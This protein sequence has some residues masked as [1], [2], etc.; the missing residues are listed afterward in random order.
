[1]ENQAVVN[2]TQE[3]LQNTIGGYDVH[4]GRE[5]IGVIY[6]LTYTPTS[7]L[8]PPGYWLGEAKT[9]YNRRNRNP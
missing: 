7:W 3:Q 1:M 6:P 5:P 8:K 2:L 9:V 4:Y